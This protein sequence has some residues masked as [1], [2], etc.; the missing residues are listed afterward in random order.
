MPALDDMFASL[1]SGAITSAVVF[2][3]M[4][5]IKSTG[6]DL[7]GSKRIAAD[8]LSCGHG[9]CLYSGET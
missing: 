7:I 9:S 2:S 3:V 6:D 5:N 1:V 4:L 8:S